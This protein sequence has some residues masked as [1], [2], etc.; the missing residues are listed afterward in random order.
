MTHRFNTFQFD[1][2]Y[3]IRFLIGVYDPFW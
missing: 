3:E 2:N 1:T